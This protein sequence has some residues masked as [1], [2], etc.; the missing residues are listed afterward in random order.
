MEDL[1]AGTYTINYYMPSLDP[2]GYYLAELDWTETWYSFGPFYPTE[3]VPG[4]GGHASFNK[5]PYY[6]METPPLGETDWRW[7]WETPGG[8]PGPENPGRDSGY[9]QIQIYDVVKA[10]ASFK[11]RGDGLCN[12]R[13]FPGADL[14]KE[15]WA[16]VRIRPDGPGILT[17]WEPISDGPNWMC[18]DEEDAN[19]D[20]D[21]VFTSINAL[22]DSYTLQ[23][24]TAS[25]KIIDVRVVVNA[26]LVVPLDDDLTIE[27]VIDGTR[28]Y[29]ETHTLTTEYTEYYS[30]W[31]IN[32]STDNS[33]TWSDIDE[34]EVG[35]KSVEAGQ[36]PTYWKVTQIYVTITYISGY[37]S[38]I[39]IF[40]VVTVTGK[41]AM[42]WGAPPP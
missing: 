34:L 31:S 12:T 37:E 19:R 29:G 10:A 40:D 41:Y 2:H 32:P 24:P 39:N 8:I 13:Y 26:A 27:V 14:R 33:W 38:L 17:Q 35:F 3:I 11:Q 23:N 1:P 36:A 25:G 9:F 15:I 42:E 5:N 16:S 18:V 28:Y 4:V 22:E 20:E 21:Y 7:I 6:W 30:T